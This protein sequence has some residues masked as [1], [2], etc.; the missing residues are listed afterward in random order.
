MEYLSDTLQITILKR[1]LDLQIMEHLMQSS[2]R[3]YSW[4]TLGTRLC[5]NESSYPDSE[6][7]QWTLQNCDA[8]I[9]KDLNL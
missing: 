2:K 1:N 6:M 5:H 9:S 3:H 8:P 4:H 7:D